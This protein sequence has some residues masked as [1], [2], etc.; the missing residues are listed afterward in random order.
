MGGSHVTSALFHGEAI[1]RRAGTSFSHGS[2]GASIVQVILDAVQAVSAT[3]ARMA[4]RV[5]VGVG[6]PGIVTGDGTV[7]LAPN[8]GI[9]NLALNDA[10]LREGLRAHVVNDANAAAL[11]EWYSGA[12][13]GRG[14]LICVTVGTGIGGGVIID[15]RLVSGSAGR[16][17]EIG[18]L[19]VAP[20]GPLCSC[21]SRGCLE[22]VSSGSAI[23]RQGQEAA[24]AGD[25]CL[26]DVCA[27]RPGMIDAQMVFEAARRG[28]ARARQIVER[29]GRYLGQALAGVVCTVDPEVIIIGGG[30][31]M[32]GD[33]FIEPVR[34]A[35][36]QSSL[37]RLRRT[38]VVRA[39][40][41]T[42]AGVIGAA[43]H[44]AIAERVLREVR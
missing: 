20:G 41:A 5:P 14:S 10:L 43:V 16:G 6:M 27:E 19:T 40:H 7:L 36:E 4:A 1:V 37:Y 21:G 31:A 11:A 44:A 13:R 28:S 23:A 38:P 35:L 25:P 24:H 2:H 22:A 39:Y 26:N 18:H 30:V 29:A 33:D 34:H 9:R 12:G 3:E 32:A 17:G 8:L 42:D 15:D